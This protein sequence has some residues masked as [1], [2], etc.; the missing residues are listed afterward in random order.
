MKNAAAEEERKKF[1][2][3]LELF[4]KYGEK[5]NSTTC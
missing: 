3:M 1:I 5:Y 4:R 2:A